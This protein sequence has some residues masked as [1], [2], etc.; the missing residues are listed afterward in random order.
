MSKISSQ[1]VIREYK[2][3]TNRLEVTNTP[4]PSY[5]VEGS[6][7]TVVDWMNTIG[8]RKGYQNYGASNAG[9]GIT[10][11]FRWQTSRGDIFSLRKVGND[12][13]IKTLTGASLDTIE[14]FNLKIIDAPTH[15]PQ[16]DSVATFA[17]VY[18]DTRKIDE[19]LIAAG[20]NNLFSWSGAYG[21]VASSTTTTIDLTE[22]IGSLGFN[23]TGTVYIEGV[24]YAY[25][26]FTG[27]QFTG[28]TPDA[29]GLTANDRV[30]EGVKSH[31]ITGKP[32]NFKV[33]YVGVFKNRAHLGCAVSRVLMVSNGTDYTNYTTGSAAGDAWISTMD[34]TCAG[35]DTSKKSIVVYGNTEMVL[36]IVYTLSADQTKEYREFNRLATAPMQGIIA[37]LA[38]VRVKNS[39]MYIT[40]EKTL[41]TLQFVE[42]ISD[43]QVLPLSDLIKNDFDATDFT[44][45][46][47]SY[48]ERNILIAAPASNIVFMYDLERGLWQA[49]MRFRN[50]T[51]GMFT[52]DE[53]G[54]LIGHDAFATASYKVFVTD[55]DNGTAIQ[56]SAVFAYNNYGDRFGNKRITTYAQDGYISANGTLT[57]T[58]DFDYR[59][60]KRT[61]DLS[62]S[63]DEVDF[64]Y[65]IE[66]SGGLGKAPLGERSLGGSSLI[67]TETARRFRYA[68]AITPTDF[69]ELRVTYSMDDNS[70]TWRLVSHAS[71]VFVTN[72]EINDITRVR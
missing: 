42:N 56:S 32:S 48:W 6:I 38:K 41:D 65:V 8:Q 7:N 66:D 72:D 59:G 26:G 36:E 40:Q 52:I 20:S 50:C 51:I 45:A 63:G 47:I 33:D 27:T 21:R 49:P 4:D 31:S 2:G 43:E 35:F 68:D 23:T 14:W 62:F 69:Y 9:D 54:D 64:L 58:L 29:S 3:Y 24:A 61:L 57:R 5:M 13:Q 12:I 25:T 18:N 67:P 15:Q 11:A 44:G 30:V 60:A 46:S 22:D 34:D 17:S 70:A 39:M 19:L 37:P 71:D 28:V 10:G 1:S 53:N 55:S 16:T